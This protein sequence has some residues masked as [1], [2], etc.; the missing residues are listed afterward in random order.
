MTVAVRKLIREA[1]FASPFRKYFFPKFAYNMTA[2]QLC[3][4]CGCLEQTR[5][6]PGCIAEAGC[7]R[8]TTTLFLAKYMEA[9]KIDKDYYALDTFGGFTARDIE[10]ESTR[11][12]DPLRFYSGFQVNKKKWFDGTMAMN[13]IRRVTAIQT[14]L[15]D[16]DFPALGPVSFCLLDVDLYRP[17]KKSLPALFSALSPGGMLVVDDCDPDSIPLDGAAQA[18]QE[19][20]R[21]IK[22]PETVMLGKLGI[23]LKTA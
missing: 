15:N 13:G 20:C 17:T 12:D 1:L 18:Y 14:D 9:A 23:I 7:A 4:L 6:I 10:Q 21:E 11:R 8:G 16:Y 2:P 3:Y 22:H 5:N 19:Y